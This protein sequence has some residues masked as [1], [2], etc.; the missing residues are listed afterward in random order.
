VGS[1]NAPPHEEA[2]FCFEQG[3]RLGAQRLHQ[4]NELDPFFGNTPLNSTT[5]AGWT[6][7]AP[8]RGA[9]TDT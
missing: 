3:L 4:D 8:T 9:N 6:S 7:P 5:S 1:I 2:C